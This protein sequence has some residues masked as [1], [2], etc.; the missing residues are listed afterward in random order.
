MKKNNNYYYNWL[1]MRRE[2]V[3]TELNEFRPFNLLFQNSWR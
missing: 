1:V 3:V 2:P